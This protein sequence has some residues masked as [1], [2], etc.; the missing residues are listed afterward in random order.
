[1]FLWKHSEE[2]SQ[3]RKKITEE[4]M[5]QKVIYHGRDL[6]EQGKSF[7]LCKIV[8][9]TGSTP[10]KKGAVMLVKENGKTIG[11]VGGGK[12]EAETEKLAMETFKTKEKS[13]IFHFKLNTKD[14]DAIDMACGGDADV[15]IQYIDAQHP[16]E[17]IEDFG[18]ITTA[19]IFGAGHV[20]LETEKI[21]R[22]IDFR[23]VVIDDRETYANRDRF[24]DADK[25]IVVDFFDNAFDEIETDENS[26][27]FILT[28]GHAGDYDVLKQALRVP[29]AYVGMIGS[30]GKNAMLYDRL[31]EA[32]YSEEE[33]EKVYAPIG[34]EIFAETPEEIAISI[35]GEAIKVRTGHGK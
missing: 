30:K 6:L 32:G 28:R 26:F 25:V 29:S 16:E 13:K 10:R 5:S 7:V 19:Y 11:S 24:P 35:A 34:V 12:L 31:R 21:L 4:N 27:I 17:F 33:I 9:S 20:G 15:L 23:T 1:M 2:D 22:Y 8:D 3:S 18:Q 14:P